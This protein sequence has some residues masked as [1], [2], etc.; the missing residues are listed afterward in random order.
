[1]SSDTIFEAILKTLPEAALPDIPN[2][3]L[4]PRQI[5][6]VE[7]YT[8]ISAGFQHS[9]QDPA[10]QSLYSLRLHGKPSPS[11]DVTTGYV[12]FADRMGLKPPSWIA[13]RK[14]LNIWMDLRGMEHV[15]RQLDQPTRYM[16]RGEFANG[17]VYADLHSTP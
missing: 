9:V 14:E 15:L 11:S 3:F 12:H 10:S 13:E 5:L 6:I 16:W 8:M 4:A 7:G 17:H 1:M 2:R